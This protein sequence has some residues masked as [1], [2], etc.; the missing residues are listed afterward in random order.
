MDEMGTWYEVIRALLPGRYSMRILWERDVI[1][2]SSPGS[3]RSVWLNQQTLRGRTPTSVVR[4][5]TLQLA[6]S[7]AVSSQ[8]AAS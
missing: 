6:P 7:R 8:W 2:V 4:A 3:G 1:V 5:L